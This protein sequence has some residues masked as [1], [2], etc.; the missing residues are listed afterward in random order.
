MA[1]IA[2]VSI[3]LTKIDKNKIKKFDKN[4]N[5]FKDGAQYYDLTVTLNDEKDQWG[6]DIAVTDAQTKEQRDAK[7]KKTYL[8]NGRVIWES[9]YEQK[10]DD[11]QKSTEA[12]PPGDLPF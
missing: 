5:P 7:E 9:K 12:I 2:S 3:N 11:Y 4:G 6:N 8:G 10:P 1:L